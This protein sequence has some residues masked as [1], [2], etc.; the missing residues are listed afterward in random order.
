M[1][2]LILLDSGPLGLAT[3]PRESN[4]ASDCKAWLK[5]ML[6]GSANVLV[7]EIA[8]Y[9]VRREPTRAGR[10]K[11][12]SRLDDLAERI[13]YLPITTQYGEGAAL[14]WAQARTQGYPTAVDTALDGD[15]LLAA[16]AQLATSLV[17]T[18]SSPRTTPD[19]SAGSPSPSSRGIDPPLIA[20]GQGVLDWLGD[21]GRGGRFRETIR[22]QPDCIQPAVSRRRRGRGG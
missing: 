10:P 14:L 8:D 5:A 4:K 21:L 15:V 17:M 16:Q 13:G 12:I 2:R 9:E 20:R 19:T 18:S 1:S 22:G 3:N 11:G 7:P 6:A